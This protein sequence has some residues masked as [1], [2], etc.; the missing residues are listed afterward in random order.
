MKTL[1]NLRFVPVS[2]ASPTGHAAATAHLLG[3]GFPRNLRPQDK[4]DARQTGS[5]G[6]PRTT[7][8]RLGWFFGK[9][10]FDE[11]PQFVAYD[12]FRPTPFLPTFPGFVRRS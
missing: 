2:Q 9:E 11:A 10:G 8:F 12:R 1:P 5:V 3:Q 4:E 6:D 7:A